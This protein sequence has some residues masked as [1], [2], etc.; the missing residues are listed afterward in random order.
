MAEWP[1]CERRRTAY[2]SRFINLDLKRL[3]ALVLKNLA[4][5]RGQAP[6]IAL[7]YFLFPALQIVFMCIV[8]GRTVR[9]LPVAVPADI[10]FASSSSSSSGDN[11]GPTFVHGFLDEHIFAPAY[12]ARLSDAVGAV[13][14]GKAVAALVPWTIKTSSSSSSPSF[15]SQ[16]GS[17]DSFSSSSSSSSSQ[18][19]SQVLNCNFST[20]SDDH[21]DNPPPPSPPTPFGV[22]LYLDQSNYVIS[23]TMF[24]AFIS[25][26]R[27]FVRSESSRLIGEAIWRQNCP[28]SS[29]ISSSFN[30][31]WFWNHSAPFEVTEV[32]YGS[33]RFRFLEF[34]LPGFLCAIVFSYALVLSAYL[35]IREAVAGLQERC[36]A[37][38]TS[39]I[40]L[41]AAH[42]ISQT[43]LYLVQQALIL[44]IVFRLFGL[45]SRGPLYAAWLLI[46]LQGLQGI[47]FGLFIAVICP[48]P[49]AAAMI[50]SALFIPAFFFSGIIWPIESMHRLAQHLSHALPLTL[51]INSL[52]YI[53]S[54]GPDMRYSQI[55]LGFSISTGYIVGLLLLTVAIFKCKTSS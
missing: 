6:A 23:Q 47:S 43:A 16:N 44:L 37:T 5:M 32:I 50:T 17:L 1:I 8:F 3:L 11:F 38:G 18:Q 20:S 54:R 27:R 26:M 34:L 48:K 31:W 22:K 41:L 49:I 10:A 51:P 7:F 52:R 30:P 35:F 14:R 4:T 42:Y 12:V 2:L 19:N 45:P 13:V 24:Y 21:H 40:E 29:S 53:L 36:L 55:L 46:F 33:T 15:S 25:S 9:Q 39:G 28:Q